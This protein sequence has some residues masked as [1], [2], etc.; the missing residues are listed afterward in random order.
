MFR[1][2][3]LLKNYS[4]S[5]YKFLNFYTN[6]LWERSLKEDPLFGFFMSLIYVNRINQRITIQITLNNLVI[7]SLHKQ[8]SLPWICPSCIR[9]KLLTLLSQN[10][11]NQCPELCKR[12]NWWRH[13]YRSSCYS[14]APWRRP[15]DTGDSAL[16]W[17]RSIW[18]QYRFSCLSPLVSPLHHNAMGHDW[19]PDTLCKTGK[20]Y[21]G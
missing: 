13:M 17:P 6:I 12:N 16:S 3:D 14:R 11:H 21:H 10:G 8:S 19:A 7:P 18:P 1:R 5:W 4:M 9:D 15:S 2:N 20:S